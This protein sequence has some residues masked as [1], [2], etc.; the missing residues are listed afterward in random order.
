MYE[1][2]TV[3]RNREGYLVNSC[4]GEVVDF[5]GYS[6]GDLSNLE[7]YEKTTSRKKE[8]VKRHERKV[9]DMKKIILDYLLS[10]MTAEEKDK[11]FEILSKV[12]KVKRPDPALLLAIYEYI[13]AKEGKTVNREYIKFMKMRGIGKYAIRQKKKL[14]RQIIKEDPVLN[15]INSLNEK[16]RWLA[17]KI[18]EILREKNVLDGRAEKR[19]RTLIEYVN[20][21]DKKKKV[22]EEHYVKELIRWNLDYISVL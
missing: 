8:V 22:L 21:H 1:E 10:V 5:E 14:I 19:K 16:D 2:C 15:Y 4:T 20:D 13:L 6:Y 17:S 9:K 11:F 18:Y 3:V 7:Y 12:E